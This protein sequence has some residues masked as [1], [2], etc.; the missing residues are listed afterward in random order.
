MWVRGQGGIAEYFKQ[1]GNVDLLQKQR[2][3]HK[4]HQV[5]YEQQCNLEPLEALFSVKL[6]ST[7]STEQARESGK[8]EVSDLNRRMES[9]WV[10]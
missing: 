10:T 5:N 3:L 2:T 6:N 9:A 4:G 7:S 8:G 1:T